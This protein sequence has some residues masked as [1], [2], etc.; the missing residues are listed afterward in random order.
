MEKQ[1][2]P[3]YRKGMRNPFCPHYSACLDEAI[4]KIWAYWDCSECDYKVEKDGAFDI[5][6]RVHDSKSGYDL[7]PD[8]F[9]DV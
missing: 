8:F 7:S 1:R 4:S 3:V 5:I 9:E 6:H 2:K